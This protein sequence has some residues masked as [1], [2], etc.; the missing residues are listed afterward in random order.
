MVTAF[1]VAH[2]LTL[3]LAALGAV[4]VPSRIVEPAIALSIAYVGVENLRS[5]HLDK[6]WRVTFPFGLVH[7]FGFAAALAEV[8]LAR[9]DVPRALLMF[10]LG[11]ELGQLGALALALPLV[12]R[13][14]RF[15]WFEGRAVPAL[16]WC[17]ALAGI[18]WFAGRVGAGQGVESAGPL[19]LEK[20]WTTPRL[21]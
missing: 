5:R 9:A 15:G 18:V 14:R 7:G 6:R 21:P 16:S 10:N 13:L 20:T 12:W 1:T 11:V 17:V 4:S 8:G 3:G 2:S 19:G